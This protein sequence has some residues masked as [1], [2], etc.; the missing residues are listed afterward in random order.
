MPTIVS[1]RKEEDGIL[2][3]KIKDPVTSVILGLK[4][5][6]TLS[7]HQKNL[8]DEIINLYLEVEDPECHHKN[9]IEV[10]KAEQDSSK[11]VKDRDSLEDEAINIKNKKVTYDKSYHYENRIEV[12]KKTDN[13]FKPNKEPPGSEAKK[14]KHELF[15]SHL[16]P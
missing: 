11:Q 12:E 2:V 1:K 4:V 9:G 13:P 16:E 15:D 14:D 8:V 5:F 3:N 7:C 6:S 10:D